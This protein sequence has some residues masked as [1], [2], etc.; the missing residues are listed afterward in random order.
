MPD[1]AI[2]VI[3]RGQPDCPSG[4]R[5]W[6]PWASATARGPS[7]RKVARGRCAQVGRGGAG[8]TTPGLRWELDA[9]M[10]TAPVVVGNDHLLRTRLEVM[11][12]AA[13]SATAER[14]RA[15]ARLYVYDALLG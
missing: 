11:T 14:F 7:R 6:T 3:W 10:I 5:E 8:L 13:K 9:G 1:Q 4:T 15:P 12:R 2:N